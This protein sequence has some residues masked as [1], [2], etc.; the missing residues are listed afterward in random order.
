MKYNIS[1]SGRGLRHVTPRIF[2]I[3]SSISTKQV[4]LECSKLVRGFRLALLASLKD[5]IFERGRGLGHAVSYT[6]LTLPTNREV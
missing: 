6:H 3:S 1:E 2:G 5:N 4:K